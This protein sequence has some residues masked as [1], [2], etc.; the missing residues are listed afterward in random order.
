MPVL[1]AVFVGK[2][3]LPEVGG[4]PII[5][6]GLPQP[7]L[8]IWG[9]PQMPPGIW[10]SP[11]GSRPPDAGYFPP[12]V[13]GP[14]SGQGGGWGPDYI[15]GGGPGARPPIAPPGGG[16]PGYPSHPWVPPTGVPE[17]PIVLPPDTVP[18]VGPPVPTHPIEGVSYGYALIYIPGQ[19]MKWVAFPVHP[20]QAPPPA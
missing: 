18:P 3:H 16:A 12:G 20:D 11:P 13:G 5:P 7:P 19:G 15:W 8:G 14:G 10:P 2:I 1:D 9:P 17:H 6:P 4:G